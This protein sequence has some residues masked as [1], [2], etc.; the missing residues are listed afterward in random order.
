MRVT[1]GGVF[2]G[3]DFFFFLQSKKLIEMPYHIPTSKM[4][5]TVYRNILPRFS[6]NIEEEQRNQK[7]EARYRQRIIIAGYVFFLLGGA[8]ILYGKSSAG[9]PVLAL[10]GVFFVIGIVS[11]II[12][13][14]RKRS[15][16][17]YSV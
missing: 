14:I 7:L 12:G 3:Y 8:L 6:P 13:F 15:A 16:I 17:T 9:L 4:N 5:S 2:C 11:T 1:A 10:S